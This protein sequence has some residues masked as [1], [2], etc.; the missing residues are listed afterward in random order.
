MRRIL[1]ALGRLELDIEPR[2]WIDRAL[3]RTP[4]QEAVL[5]FEVA[6]RSREVMPAHAD[7]VDRI[8]AATALANG[9]TFVTADRSLIDARPCPILA[10][11]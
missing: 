5:N 1:L 7:P 8:L 4:A 9:L 3:A 11:R 6:L 2:R 10:A